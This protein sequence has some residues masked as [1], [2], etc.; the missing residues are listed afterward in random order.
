MAVYEALVQAAEA[1]VENAKLNL[2]YCYIHSP[3]DG[4]AGMRLV[5]VGNV[6]QTNIYDRAAFADPA[7]G[8]DLRGLHRH[9][10]RS[11]GG[12]T[13]AVPEDAETLVRIPSDDAANAGARGETDV[14][15]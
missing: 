5:D 13:G 15:R 11:S 14:R 9:R 12:A 3:I 8:P 4:R 6:V 2:E 7:H 1:A 10:G